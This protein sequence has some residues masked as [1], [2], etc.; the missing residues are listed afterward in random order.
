MAVI[1]ETDALIDSETAARLLNV[2]PRNLINRQWRRRYEVPTVR[3]GRA[4]RFSVPSLR[5][6]VSR[7]SEGA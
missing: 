7:Q 2:S 5:E 4:V 1:T 6:W 3:V